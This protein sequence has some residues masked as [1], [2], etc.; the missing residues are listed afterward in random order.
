MSEAISKGLLRSSHTPT[1][2]GL[3]VALSL[4]AIGGDLGAEIDLSLLLCECSLDDDARLF[5]ES[6]SRF[7]VSCA[8]ENQDSLEA[9]FQNLPCSRVGVVTSERR[10]SI[11]DNGR[12]RIV[13]IDLAALR[14]AFKETLDGV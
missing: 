1:L 3:A 12:R 7:V 5:S 6:N 13:D 14:R 10:L 9:L 8:P 11:H 4:A 2:G